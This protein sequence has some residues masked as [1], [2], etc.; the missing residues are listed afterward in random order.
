M[1]IIPIERKDNI[2]DKTSLFVGKPSISGDP[3]V[4]SSSSQLPEVIV[5][6]WERVG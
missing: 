5:T 6:T 1:I 2:C 3:L 4:F